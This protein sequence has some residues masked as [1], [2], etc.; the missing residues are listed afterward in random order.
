MRIP[1]SAI[2]AKG[3]LRKLAKEDKGEE[4][5]EEP[6]E[7]EEEEEDEEEE[8]VNSKRKEPEQEQG[9]GQIDYQKNENIL[10]FLHNDI[11]VFNDNH[12]N[13]NP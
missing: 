4:E 8:E 1:V 7:E 13:D 12:S 6:Q 11:S 3:D 10:A 5:E 9:Q 2:V